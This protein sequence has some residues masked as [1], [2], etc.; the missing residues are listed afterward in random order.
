MI[1][2]SSIGTF[3]FGKIDPVDTDACGDRARYP[4]RRGRGVRKVGG[5]LKKGS[6]RRARSLC[7]WFRGQ[8]FPCFL[9]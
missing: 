4:R 5:P 7:L 9:D 3:Y 6:S 1:V 8:L 2:S